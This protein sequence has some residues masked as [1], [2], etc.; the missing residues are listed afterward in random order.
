MEKEIIIDNN[1][2]EITRIT[3]FIEE[4]GM[5]LKLPSEITMSINLAIEEAVTNIIQ[6]GYPKGISSDIILKVNIAPRTLTF[7]IIDEGLSF[8]PTAKESPDNT[9]SLEQR[10]TEG[11]G[12]FL[13]RRTMDKIEY[14]TNGTSN[15][16]TLIKQID[17]NF[18]QEATLKT[19]LCKI[20]G[21]TV[22]AVEGR[23]DTA[24]TNEF[25]SVI[26]PLLNDSNPDIIL[27]C[28]GLSY[29]SS[30]GLRSLIVLQKSVLQHRGSLVIEAI[31][32][33][34]LKIFEMTGCS[35]LF[36]IR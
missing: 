32:P 31:R 15:Q 14:H 7:Y 6:H 23:L 22:L 16:L 26:Q 3:Q 20:E 33:E 27:N 30:S 1:L 10:L 34:I 11:L 5:S 19:N 29:I 35:T 36:T 24:N 25:N 17:N 4:M 21:V 28:E 2:D 9:I 12:L 18:K 8:D 13:I